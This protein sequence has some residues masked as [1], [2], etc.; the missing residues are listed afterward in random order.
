MNEPT[1]FLPSGVV[2]PTEYVTDA[3]LTFVRDPNHNVGPLRDEIEAMLYRLLY[4]RTLGGFFDGFFDYIAREATSLTLSRF[5]TGN[6]KLIAATQ[7]GKRSHINAQLM[8]AI[9]LALQV[10]MWR[11]R[12]LVIRSTQ[13]TRESRELH[14]FEHL[15]QTIA[16]L[17]L[18]VGQ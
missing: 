1:P 17:N 13:A 3:W 5:L 7:S 14:P 10:T 9:W 8:R 2:D 16:E 18:R 4:P 15:R 6:K 12:S 11:T